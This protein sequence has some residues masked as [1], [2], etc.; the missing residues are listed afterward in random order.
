MAGEKSIFNDSFK[1]FDPSKQ[2]RK[3]ARIRLDITGFYTLNGKGKPIDCKLI[4][5]GTGGMTFQS[6]MSLYPGDR[7]EV[8]FKLS[9]KLISV[10]GEI[11]RTSGKDCVMKYKDLIPATEEVIQGYIHDSFFDDKS[12][13]KPGA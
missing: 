12:K 2:K 10:P 11:V 13:K 5:L 8:E 1:V 6:P 7:L 3:K 4:D 9:G